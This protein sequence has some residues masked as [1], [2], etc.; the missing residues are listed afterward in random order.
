M[1]KII[2]PLLVIG[3][4]FNACKKKDDTSK[5]VDIYAVGYERNQ[6]D[7]RV[8]K[9]WKNG[10]ATSL[11]DG[12]FD[13]IADAVVV[14]GTDVYI[15]GSQFN[16]SGGKDAILWKNG[17]VT[18]VLEQLNFWSAHSLSIS[19]ND[20]YILGSEPGYRG[21]PVFKLYK[22]GEVSYLSDGSSTPFEARSIAAAG[23]DNYIGGSINDLAHVWKNG[24]ATDISGGKKSYG[25]AIAISENDVYVGGQSLEGKYNATIW[26]NGVA[27]TL[28]NDAIYHSGVTAIVVSGND[29]YAVG[30]LSDDDHN[31]GPIKLWKN[32][33][34]TTLSNNLNTVYKTYNVSLAV[35][36][37][38]VYVASG[39][40]GKA[41]IWKNGIPTD[42]TNGSFEAAVNQIVVVPK[43]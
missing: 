11:T 33:V 12:S 36:G 42:L 27:T 1:K 25:F 41:K 30:R 34:E 39:D 19:G 28:N 32:G 31:M 2:L 35:S 22:N 18:N 6:Q 38:D 4:V 21:V 23:S 24:V 43:Q 17:V 3:L 16:T 8:A 5:D 20:L 29:V 14:S 15:T 10:V 26:K 37:N 13:A 9:L 40:E 7:I